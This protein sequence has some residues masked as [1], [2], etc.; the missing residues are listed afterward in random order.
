MK[1]H[2]TNAF[3]GVIDYLAYPVGLL[4]LAPV[5]LRALGMER[6]GIWAIATAAIS[7]GAIIASGFGDANIRAVAITLA[8]D[9]RK[10]LIETVRSALG[11]HLVLGASLAC[12]GWFTAPW[13]TGHIARSRPE[14]AIDC[15]WS[16]RIAG[17]LALIRAVETVCVSTQRAF[18]RYGSAIQITV[19]AR[20]LALTVAGVVPFYLRSV[21]TVLI[22]SLAISIVAL[23]FQLKQLHGLLGVSILTPAFHSDITR[24]LLVFG[25]FTWLCSVVGLLF[26]QADR[27]VAGVGFGAAAVSSY[28]F[29]VQLAQ[30]IYG[31]S[32]AG[33]H[34]LFP[35]LTT[36]LAKNDTKSLR[37]GVLI[38][39][40]ANAIFVLVALS[41]LLSNGEAILRFWAGESIAIGARE[42]LPS[43]TWSS[44]FSALGV[45]GCYSM[46]ALGRPG[47]VTAFNVAGGLAMIGAVAL[48]APHYGLAGIAYA[49]LLFGPTVLFLYVPLWMTLNRQSSQPDPETRMPVCEEV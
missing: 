31:L 28:A 47:T 4:L 16:L 33:L 21:S 48:L 32:A 46:L 24:R 12:V 43:I 8:T 7:T 11:I 18:S 5:I 1:F 49:R 27:L 17:L 41:V 14:L 34:F 20:L 35:Y 40:A 9:D 29:C 10:A 22:A 26:G 39:T 15:L 30:P 38:T 37:H 13:M 36:H 6:Y 25:G 42:L 2:L 3:F 44:A 45:T 19:V 23:W